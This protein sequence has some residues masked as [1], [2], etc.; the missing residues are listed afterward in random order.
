M[1]SV[2]AAATLT[3]L[4][5]LFYANKAKVTTSSEH[6]RQN[7]SSRSDDVDDDGDDEKND[8]VN[9]DQLSDYRLAEQPT[10]YG[11][12][13]ARL[14]RVVQMGWTDA[15]QV[16]KIWRL[17]HLL[18]IRAMANRECSR[19]IAEAVIIKGEGRRVT[20][21][22]INE[23][24]NKESGVANGERLDEKLQR[25]KLALKYNKMLRRARDYETI[26][27][28]LEKDRGQEILLHQIKPSTYKP[29]FVLFKD[30]EVRALLFVIR[31]THSI[32]D[33]LT[34]LTAHSSPHH[35]L[36]PDGSG[37]VVVGYAHAGFLAN[38]R[39]L[40]KNATDELRKAREA[41]PNY[42]F[43]VVGHSLGGGVGVLLAQMLR[44]A[45]PESFSD[46]RMIAFGCPSMLS[47]ELAANCAPWTTSLINRGDAVPLLSYSRAED[48]RQQITNT[49]VEQKILQ[50]FLRGRVK[51]DAE[52]GGL[53]IMGEDAAGVLVSFADE[54]TKKRIANDL[55]TNAPHV[56]GVPIP[57][58]GPRSPEKM[59]MKRTYSDNEW[60][61]EETPQN[62]QND[63][64]K[65]ALGSIQQSNTTV[66]AKPATTA[67]TSIARQ[68][69][70][71]LATTAATAS[72]S[73]MSVSSRLASLTVATLLRCT[74]PRNSNQQQQ[75][76]QQQQEKGKEKVNLS[77]KNVAALKGGV[78]SHFRYITAEEE[79]IS[80]EQI[81][82]EVLDEAEPD[83]TERVLRLQEEHE[84]AR[85]SEDFH[86]AKIKI[87]KEN[88]SPEHLHESEALEPMD[89]VEDPSEKFE[90]AEDAEDAIRAIEQELKRREASNNETTTTTTQ[91]HQQKKRTL[92]VPL[93]PAGQI[94]HMIDKSAAD[95]VENLANEQPL[96][97]TCKDNNA[98]D[99][100]NANAFALY[101]DV[102]RDAYNAIWLNK[103][104]ISDHFI[105]RYETS[106]LDIC[107]SLDLPSASTALNK[108]D[109]ASDRDY[110]EE[111]T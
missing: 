47:E 22:R 94:L 100:K 39:W 73:A 66:A 27:G 103:N 16:L 74:S 45:H 95:S 104:M 43:M 24:V 1:A 56:C 10:T 19:E 11:E 69:R 90:D 2:V 25:I 63:A 33:S 42:E 96:V 41:N 23:N 106:L 58:V 12:T 86:Y 111:R 48:M 31:G 83:A 50:R 97:E 99:K 44:D 109:T 79:R 62:A 38:A 80:N 51:G 84:I 93:F 77:P 35:A 110:E 64:S 55:L 101:S 60:N 5:S 21:E 15:M 20:K 65:V 14:T 7:S 71:F 52:L 78:A 67:S 98:K 75:Q 102:K 46:V 61:E 18:A 57:C 34:A 82:E 6:K 29:A 36:K 68:G 87:S 92:H 76:Q 91:K 85:A 105:P 8:E 81:S 30:K 26:E 72:K 59:K 108:S 49:A 32:K 4:A 17:D 9:K 89:E 88:I 40:M 70:N 53:G 28:R 13:A 54:E 37:D 3:T 107:D